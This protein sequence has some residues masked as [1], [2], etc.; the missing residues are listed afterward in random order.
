M[1]MIELVRLFA[2]AATVIAAI[3]VALNLSPTAMVWGFSIFVVASIAW[4]I[5]GW[6]DKKLSLLIQNAVLLLVN[7]AGI[8]RWLPR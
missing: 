1:E 3:L 6:W 8:Y 5:D 4:M 7:L 2:A